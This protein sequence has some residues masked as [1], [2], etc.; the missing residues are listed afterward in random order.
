MANLGRLAAATDW[1]VLL[2]VGLGH[3]DADAASREVAAASASLGPRLA[4]FE[5]G[6]EP[7]SFANK[8]LRAQP[9]GFPQYQSDV[10]AYRLAIAARTPNVPLVGPDVGSGSRKWLEAEAATEHPRMLTAHYYSLGCHGAPPQV[11]DLLS[12]RVRNDAQKTLT[13]FAEISQTYWLP[14]R[15]GEANNVSCGGKAGVSETFATALWALD[16]TER[17]MANGLAGINFHGSIYNCHGYT[18]LCA[19]NRDDLAAGKLTANPEWYALLMLHQLVGD[20]PL[21]SRMSPRHRNVTATAWASGGGRLHILLINDGMPGSP[22]LTVRLR[23]PQRFVSGTILRLFGPS[24]S[25]TSGVLLG[26]QQVADNG[27]WY[28]P[29]TLPKLR[30]RPGKLE[31]RLSPASAALVTVLPHG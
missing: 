21:T 12:R 28:P 29:A 11:S 6:N 25:A 17:A 8:N 7:H 5:V 4:G 16:F 19:R 26:G 10:D 14:F 13:H 23:L 1:S 18:P 27:V 24:P 2:G 20:R 31:L 15:I 22:Q 30:G 3:Y 9:W